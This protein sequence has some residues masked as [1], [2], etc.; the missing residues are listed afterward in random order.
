MIRLGWAADRKQEVGS[1]RRTTTDPPI[2]QLYTKTAGFLGK[3]NIL[4]CHVSNF[5]PPV[6]QVDLQ[7]N[8]ATIP[9]A[10]QTE[11]VFEADWQYYLTKYVAFVPQKAET[12]ACVVTHGGIS[13]TYAWEPEK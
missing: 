11:M 2:V 13:R 10:N 8:G 6:I 4:L 7:R 9:K 12:Y 1:S 3:S 5:Y